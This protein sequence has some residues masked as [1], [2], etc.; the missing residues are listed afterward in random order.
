VGTISAIQ[1]IYETLSALRKEWVMTGWS[2]DSRHSCVCSSF[3]ADL[4]ENALAAIRQAFP[5]RYSAGTLKT[6]DSEIQDLAD[7]TG[8][9]RADQRLFASKPVNYTFAYGLWWPWGDEVTT[10]LRIGLS[11]HHAAVELS[12]LQS[13]FRAE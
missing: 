4:E 6:A 11:G 5:L 7:R 13:E 10:S 12:T 9:L 2:W 1:P 3:G 8:G